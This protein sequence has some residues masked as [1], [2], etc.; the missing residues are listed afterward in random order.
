MTPHP[1]TA[2]SRWLPT[3]PLRDRECLTYASKT[4]GMCTNVDTSQNINRLRRDSL[5]ELH[6]VRIAPTVLPGQ[7]FFMHSCEADPSAVGI[8]ESRLMIGHE[9]LTLQA[10]PW[11][12]KESE[13]QKFRESLSKGFPSA[14]EEVQIADLAGNA[15]CGTVLSA[16]CSSIIMA[17]PWVDQDDLALAS[18]IELVKSTLLAA[19]DL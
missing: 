12:S 1:T 18:A 4:W 6:K 15:V 3:L 8:N 13:F 14:S 11:Q 17:V 10:Y 5:C 16:L 19:M 7:T 9:M 2:S